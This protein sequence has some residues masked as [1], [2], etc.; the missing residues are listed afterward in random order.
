MTARMQ[1]VGRSLVAMIDVQANHYPT[2]AHGER[3][4]ERLVR[5]LRTT[6]ILEVLC[7]R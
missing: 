7:P 6:R 4:L 2:V 3:T 5:F 1:D